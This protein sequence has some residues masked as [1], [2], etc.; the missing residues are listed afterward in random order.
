[1]SS[2]T[3]TNSYFSRWVI[4]PPTGIICVWWR[5]SRLIDRL[6]FVRMDISHVWLIPMLVQDG[7]VDGFSFWSE[8]FHKHQGHIL[9]QTQFLVARTFVWIGVCY[10]YVHSIVE[11]SISEI[12]RVYSPLLNDIFVASLRCVG[13]WMIFVYSKLFKYMINFNLNLDVYKPVSLYFGCIISS[14]T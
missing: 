12:I 4:A 8:V 2:F 1:M 6:M 11:E 3:L 9:E 5:G 7:H 14:I 13:Y 10:W